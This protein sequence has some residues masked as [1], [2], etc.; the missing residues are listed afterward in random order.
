MIALIGGSLALS[1]ASYLYMGSKLVIQDKTSYIYDYSFSQVRMASMAIQHELE[2]FNDFKNR[3]QSKDASGI[4]LE[5]LA[6]QSYLQANY[7]VIFS[8]KGP[9][10]NLKGLAVEKQ[11]GVDLAHESLP[12]PTD[13][14]TPSGPP[15]LAI[16]LKQ[17]TMTVGITI[18]NLRLA[19]M[20]IKMTHPLFDG[21][22]KDFQI[23]VMDN[24]GHLITAKD[25]QS[26]ASFSPF[27]HDL[28]DDLTKTEFDAGVREVEINHQSYLM[29][30][31]QVLSNRIFILSLVP[32][33]MALSTAGALAK[34]SLGLGI[35]IFLLA[36]GSTL[37]LIRSLI[38]RVNELVAGTERVS[39][40]DFSTKIRVTASAQDEL[41]S[42]AQSFNKMG[43]EI[44]KLL[45]ATAMSARME[46]ELET[47]QIVQSRFFP[48]KVLKLP[49]FILHGASISASECGGDWWH[50]AQV[51]NYLIVIMGDAT[52]H[53]ASAALITAS[54]HSAFSLMVSELQRAKRPLRPE[55]EI[56]GILAN[57]LN[58]ALILAAGELSTFPCLL[59]AI[60][61]NTLKMW[62]FNAGHPQ[63]FL[64]RAGSKKYQT[65][66]AGTSIPLGQKA[67]TYEP[68]LS[69][70]DLSPGDQVLWYTDGLFDSRIS[71][72]KKLKKKQFMDE[73]KGKTDLIM[74]NVH[75]SEN[76]SL[77]D[78]VLAQ[79]DQFFGKNSTDRPDD[80]TIL[81]FAIPFTVV[82]K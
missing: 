39:A 5:F 75:T 73:L 43:E 15:R 81:S 78:F 9:Q 27:P 70:T 7:L 12:W 38:V 72:G 66:S 63:P 10:A 55:T 60:D 68:T 65:L 76:S 58:S 56:L 33:T 77:A 18:S 36:I 31:D 3:I 45:K 2:K 19:V 14:L 42:L 50:Y 57:S 32:S 52:G 62:S 64:F 21:T 11:I 54:I 61:L 80:I 20:Q 59:A 1:L 35:S 6:E 48:P 25:T 37:L 82:T 79:A 8:Q 40:G 67:F 41:S 13:Q 44:Q 46:Q 24:D 22:A 26:A 23:L 34:K 4:E 51:Q 17:Q 74:K 16:D 47:A 49:N 69:I 28:L 53:G 71:D 30:Y 29:G